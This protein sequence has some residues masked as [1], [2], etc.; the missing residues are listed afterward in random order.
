MR[1]LAAATV[2]TVLPALAWAGEVVPDGKA[3]F[4]R[5]KT[6]A[7]DWEGHIEKPD[8]PPGAVSYRLASGG[9]VVMETLFPGGA[10]EMI[11]MYYLE[12]ERLVLTHYCAAGN[13]PRLRLVSAS[14]EELRFDFEGGANVDPHESTFLHN[15][16]LSFVGADRL[17]AAWEFHTGDK[18]A[19]THRFF[20]KRR[21]P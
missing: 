1:R 17:E 19:G 3:A 12:G 21:K 14:A 20:L 11:S 4:E 6:L 8:G 10:H 16:R 13:Q 7:G 15:G 2:L 9:S 18:P 5:L